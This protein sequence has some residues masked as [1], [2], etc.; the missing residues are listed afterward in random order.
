MNF[1]YRIIKQWKLKPQDMKTIILSL[2]LSAIVFV[3]HAQDTTR[4]KNLV[5][6]NEDA[7]KTEVSLLN[8][9]IYIKDKFVGDTTFVRVGRRN[10]QIIEHGGRTNINVIK[11]EKV[12]KEHN[13]HKNFDGHWA[14]FELGYNSFYNTDYSMYGGND[15]MDLRQP[16]S[17][18]VN[19]NFWEADIPI[20]NHRIG[21]VSGMGWTMNNYKFD[22]PVTLERTNGIINPVNLDESGLEKSKLTVSYLTVPLLMEFQIP[23]NGDLNQLFVAG[24]VIGGVNIGSHTKVKYK[25]SKNKDHGSFSINPFK[26]ALTARVG[27]KDICLFANYSLSPLF[28]DGKGPEIYPFTIGISLCNLD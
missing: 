9:H 13:R 16:N 27:V 19:I 11:D 14:A 28:K 23:V 25:H 10:V 20:V 15:F 4:V 24:G 6:V 2:F 3:A 12:E 7:D 22:N 5:L 8:N 17:M 1:R 18:E 26:Y 21:L